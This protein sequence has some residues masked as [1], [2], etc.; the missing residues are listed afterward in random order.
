M[1]PQRSRVE[2]TSPEC[3]IGARLERKE[4]NRFLRGR[5]QYVG[6]IQLP[7]MRDVAFVRSPVA[8]AILSSIDI[9][10]DKRG[11]VF[12]AADLVGVKPIEAKVGLPGY[13]SSLQPIL[14][15]GKV[16][17]VG[18]LIAAC[19]ADS[20]AEAEDIADRVIANFDD[21][22]VVHDMVAARRSGS[23]LIHEHWTDNVFLESRLVAGDM[24]SAASRAAVSVS[25][26]IR[27][28]RQCISPLEGRG[29]V[30]HW[31][32]RQEQL[33]LWSSTQVPH[34]IRVGLSESLGLPQGQIRVI[35]PDV[36]GGFGYKCVLVPE[37]VCIAW[38]ALRLRHP[39]RWIED[40]RE[41]LTA[42]A[43]CRE[44]HYRVTAHADARGRLLGLEVEASVD[45]GAYSVYPFSACLE[46]GQLPGMLPGPYV[47]PAFDATSY[48]VATNKAPIV[49]YR[50]V[51]RPGAC[52]AL[53][54]II[55]AVA[56]AVGREPYVV[57]IENVVPPEAM[58]FDN[59]IGKHFDGGDYP[60]CIRRAAEAIGVDRIRERQKRGER[61][62]RL[63]GVGFAFFNEQG[64]VGTSV[65]AKWGMPFTPGFEQATA[66]LAPDGM[67]EV[68]VGIQSHGQGL[69][70]S[71]AQVAHTVLG[72]DVHS[73]NVVHGDT[74]LT[75]FST[76]TW[77]SRS[78][79]M[80]GGAVAAAC[81]E[82]ATRIALIGAH[83]MR[84]DVDAVTVAGG[85]VI[86][87]NRS[88]T[89]ADIANTWYA[90]PQDLPP[91]VHTGGL[92]VTV[93][94]KP[95]RDSGTFS[96]AT[97]AALVAVDPLVGQIEILDYVVVEDGGTLV[98]PMIVDGQIFGGTAQG[99]G[100]ALYEEMPFNEL[101][102]PLASTLL[103]YLLP[104]S[105]EIPS[106][107]IF[108]METPSQNTAFG[109]KG[110]GEGGAIGPPAA[111]LNAVNDALRP[112]GARVTDCPITPRCVLAGIDA[113]NVDREALA[114]EGVS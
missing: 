93:G 98:N 103:D 76:G 21:L 47:L 24:R 16:R 65:Y 114:T 3:G 73:I 82:L 110:I 97:H 12:C 109:V 69:E 22:P 28:A 66:R 45:S 64:A 37:E 101:G 81:R 39:V 35:A 87:P 52:L 31:D 92:E 25:R 26:E 27:T 86:A 113:A 71:L 6:D 2:H 23:P 38:L 94:Y 50:G 15:T 40:R 60:A 62:G 30:A 57:R 108:H 46:S 105:N 72:I 53:E 32:S 4:D 61:D 36:G 67:L 43:N 70:T 100:T 5:G 29:A 106:I 85:R 19:V 9:P 51:A 84:S 63:I 79:V 83:V 77:G 17:H 56:E 41:Q 10:D 33:V 75:P 48:G 102:Q 55:D 14:A 1:E 80:A 42:G 18:E 11:Q 112:L 91:N 89:I 49:P 54:S 13:K 88:M 78:M 59:I 8:H 34:L 99:I 58:P 104:G 20:R 44:H 7:G 95:A 68:R 96:Y 90:T 111:L 107:R 74:A